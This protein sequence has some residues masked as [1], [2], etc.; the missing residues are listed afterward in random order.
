M[1]EKV[2][3]LVVLGIDVGGKPHAS[4][5]EERDASF[6][7]RA[8][9]MRGC[10]VIRVP[11]ENTELHAVSEGLPPGKILATRKAVGTCCAGVGCGD[12][13]ASRGGMPRGM[14]AKVTAQSRTGA[15]LPSDDSVNRVMFAF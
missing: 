3:I 9:E 10:H 8:A 14:P 4:R 1:S 7:L 2:P 11:P 15:K 12:A 13:Q 5:F 6:V